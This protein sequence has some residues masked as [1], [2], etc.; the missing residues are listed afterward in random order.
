MWRPLWK[1]FSIL[2]SQ[3][4]SN[5]L[6]RFDFQTSA[7]IDFVVVVVVL[8]ISSTNSGFIQYSW[9]QSLDFPCVKREKLGLDSNF[10]LAYRESWADSQRPPRSSA[11]RVILI[12][13]ATLCRGKMKTCPF[14]TSNR[15]LTRRG[16]DNGFR[17]WKINWLH[18]I[19]QKWW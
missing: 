17:V 14:N 6:G 19:L 8:H 18:Y 13:Q 12:V 2:L 9:L 10:H 15:Y 1:E 3:P 11:C 7:F 16:R 5:F 4:F